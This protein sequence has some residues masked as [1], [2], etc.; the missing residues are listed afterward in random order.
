MATSHLQLRWLQHIQAQPAL[1][2]HF[3]SKLAS[4]L[5]HLFP[6]KESL[7][8]QNSPSKPFTINS[9]TQQLLGTTVR[10]S[11]LQFIEP[12]SRLMISDLTYLHHTQAD[13]ARFY[14]S[15]FL[16]ADLADASPTDLINNHPR[17]VDQLFDTIHD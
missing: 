14:P 3:A 9:D 17:I 1:L 12:F 7:I 8:I 10:A 6:Y 11:Q 13:L 16:E 2:P 4:D 15:Q 5:Q